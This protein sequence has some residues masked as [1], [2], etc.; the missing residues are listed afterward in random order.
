MT[1]SDPKLPDPTGAGTPP[2]APPAAGA[3]PPVGEAPGVGENPVQPGA[4]ADVGAAGMEATTQMPLT[5]LPPG[6]DGGVPPVGPDDT[7]LD[8]DD[9]VPW[10]KK[11]AGIAAIAILAL[12]LAALLAWLI[13]GGNDDDDASAE[14]SRLTIE[15]RDDSGAVLDRGF[16]VTVDGPAGSEASYT[17]LRPASGTPGQ[18]TGD[19]TGTD[20]RVDFEWQPDDSVEDPAT[21]AATV[22]VIESVPPGWTPPGPLVDCTLRRVGENDS[23]VSMSVEIRSNDPESDQEVVYAFPNY[24]FLPGDAVT[25]KLTSTAPVETTTTTSTTVTETTVPETT[26]PETTVVETTVPP[27]AAPTT[28]PPTA[29]PTTVPPVT[30]S[31][32]DIIQT[33]PDLSGVKSLVDAA[34]PSILALLS[35]VN[36]TITL[37]A[38]SNDAI[39]TA[40]PDLTDQAAVTALLG[41]HV[42]STQ[43]LLA[44]DVLAL[45][46]VPV[47]N[48][49]PQPVDAAAQTIGGATV[50]Q[51]DLPAANGVI[52]I[53][54]AVMPIQP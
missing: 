15:A 28:P 37:F 39:T 30:E 25:C 52:H 22:E 53:I 42:D 23:I 26:T 21:W 29:A 4:G 33:N 31:A 43:V 50:V 47:A 32:W 40:N 3:T 2:P 44:A 54:G 16:L 35:D 8:G 11:P 6:A 24:V 13:F 45:P 49:G 10:Y 12:A 38:P 36:A 34:D 19:G 20:G 5:D 14:T 46:S 17:W 51:A 7:G 1:D 41:A 18:I 48:G 27:T 9:E